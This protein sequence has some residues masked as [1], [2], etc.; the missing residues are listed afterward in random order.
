MASTNHFCFLTL[1]SNDTTF[2]SARR[3]QLFSGTSDLFSAD[4]R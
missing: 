1:I 2:E 4:G 3:L